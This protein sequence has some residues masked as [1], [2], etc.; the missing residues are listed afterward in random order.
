MRKAALYLRVSA[1]DP[2]PAN[3]E[4]ELREI[5]SRIDCEIVKVYRE[6]RTG[7]TS[8]QKRPELEKLCSDAYNRKFDM[9]MVWSVDQLG[10]S[11]HDLVGFLSEIHALKVDLYLHKQGLDTTT[12]AGQAIFEMTGVFAEFE[13]AVI[14]NRFRDGWA[15]AKRNGKLRGR[16]RITPAVESA[17]RDALRKGDAGMLKIATRFGVGT[18]TVQRIRAEM[19]SESAASDRAEPSF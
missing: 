8:D 6:E 13:R 14:R 1:L 5:A 2:T 10:Y 17:I 15:K 3:H 7:G 9:A 18:G 16:R 4:H 11:L 19:T 12:P